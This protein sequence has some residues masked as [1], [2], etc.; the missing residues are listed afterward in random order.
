MLQPVAKLHQT[1]KKEFSVFIFSTQLSSTQLR[2]I[3]YNEIQQQNKCDESVAQ[4]LTK[5]NI[6]KGHWS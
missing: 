4:E 1:A 6:K 5:L 2:K 3:R